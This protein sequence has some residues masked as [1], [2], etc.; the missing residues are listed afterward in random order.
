MYTN[1]IITVTSAAKTIDDVICVYEQLSN[2]ELM[3]SYASGDAEAFAILYQRNKAP[4]YRYILRQTRQ[5]A[6]ADELSQDVW[7]NI[8]K[9]RKNYTARA[10]F[11]TYLFQIAHNRLVDYWRKTSHRLD[12]IQEEDDCDYHDEAAIEPQQQL[13]RDQIAQQLLQL[14]QALPLEQREVF[15]LKE[16]SGL[17]L[18]QIAQ[19]TNVNTETAKSRLRYA[20]AKLREGLKELL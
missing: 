11:T 17:S 15:V 18:E 12:T 6:I 16:E 9:A 13:A 14:L 19:V 5:Q 8:I 2:E 1:D 20:M 10:K 4:L 7:T 3:S